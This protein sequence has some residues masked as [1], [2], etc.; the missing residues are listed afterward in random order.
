MYTH[1]QERMD[2]HGL[3]M[4][5][6]Q[7]QTVAA[8]LVTGGVLCTIRK[9]YSRGSD[10]EALGLELLISGARA[11]ALRACKKKKSS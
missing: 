4:Q 9:E 3:T 7:L 8:P 10:D 11:D 6:L 2:G 5:Q 1:A